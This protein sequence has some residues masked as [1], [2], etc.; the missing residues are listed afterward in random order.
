VE[1]QPT[2]MQL[3]YRRTRTRVYRFVLLYGLLP[4]G[5]EVLIIYLKAPPLLKSAG[6]AAAL[7]GLAAST[8]Y[9]W[10]VWKCPACGSKLWVGGGTLG[11]KC[12]GCGTQLYEPRRSKSG[13]VYP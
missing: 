8:V 9:V 5:F 10:R 7:I 2:P 11:G 3:E 6:M 4:F 12:L 1:T 13:R